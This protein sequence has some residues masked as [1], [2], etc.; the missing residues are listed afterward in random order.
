MGD[1]QSWAERAPAVSTRWFL[2]PERADG[3]HGADHIRRVHVLADR[4]TTEL[5]WHETA[6][7]RVLAAA[8]WHDIGRTHDGEEPEHGARSAERAVVL[9]L[10]GKLDAAD[11][12]AALFAVR[13]HSL[14]DEAAYP[15]AGET[16]LEILWLLKDADALDRVR[17]GRDDLDPSRL[18]FAHSHRLIGFA[19]RLYELL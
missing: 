19:A 3:I 11:A 7:R 13:L 9:G 6:R 16:D 14:A 2:R 5:G 17:L 15:V 1:V 8:L 4:L 10:A 18:R 12:D